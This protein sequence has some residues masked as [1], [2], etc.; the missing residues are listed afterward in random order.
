MPLPVRW[1][2]WESVFLVSVSSE[3]IS[4]SHFIPSSQ[5]RPLVFQEFRIWLFSESS[6]KVSKFDLTNARKQW[7]S[8][9]LNYTTDALFSF[10]QNFVFLIKISFFLNKQI[11]M[12]VFCFLVFLV[13]VLI[14]SIFQGKY[15]TKSDVWS[16]GVTL[17]EILYLCRRRPF[18]SLTDEEVVENIGLLRDD[19]AGADFVPL[20]R[21]PPPCTKD[22]AD[23]MA[24]CWRPAEVQRPTFCQI[25]LFL[26]RKNLGYAPISWKLAFKVPEAGR[27]PT[28]KMHFPGQLAEP[29]AEF[30]PYWL[31]SS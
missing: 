7:A 5:L 24:E 8:F 21:P 28:E 1:M 6:E 22:I 29:A 4:S 26:Q 9:K 13:F 17:W 3:T 10:V 2:A 27:I 31:I 23:L 18:D 15:T 14:S 12:E 16:F 11:I 25:H 19:T 20:P 30:I